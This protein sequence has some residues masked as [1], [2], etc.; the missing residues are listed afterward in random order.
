MVN[1]QNWQQPSLEIEASVTKRLNSNRDIAV[2]LL[3]RNTFTKRWSNKCCSNNIFASK[4]EPVK[5]SFR[6]SY[7]KSTTL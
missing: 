1:K 4:T 2:N 6:F 3:K 7:S 5:V